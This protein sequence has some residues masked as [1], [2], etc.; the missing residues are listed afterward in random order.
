MLLFCLLLLLFL[1]L[2]FILLCLL[3]LSGVVDLSR[4]FGLVS[5]VGRGLEVF[6]R[7]GGF[8]PLRRLA[9]LC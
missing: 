2:L 9:E 8:V 3:S 7:G 4:L 5:M 1:L 6:R